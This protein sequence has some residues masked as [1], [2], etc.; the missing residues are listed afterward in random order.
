MSTLILLTSACSPNGDEGKIPDA[1]FDL[2]QSSLTSKG[3]LNL[4]KTIRSIK[5]LPGE[6][7]L[8]R[9]TRQF[10]LDEVTTDNRVVR[11][12]F[13]ALAAFASFSFQERPAAIQSRDFPDVRQLSC[14]KVYFS[15]SIEGTKSYIVELTSEKNELLLKD[16]DGTQI[17]YRLRNPRTLEVDSTAWIQD[18]CPDYPSVGFKKS[19]VI[20]WGRSG[21]FENQPVEIARSLIAKISIAINNMPAALS[22]VATYSTSDMVLASPADLLSLRSANLDKAIQKCPYNSKPPVGEESNSRD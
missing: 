15:S 7:I 17:T 1:A 18:P 5:N 2:E 21:D 9:H 4:E 3:C 14:E 8:R 20:A 6:A 11:R 16:D 10:E 13:T 12:N 19:E 22:K